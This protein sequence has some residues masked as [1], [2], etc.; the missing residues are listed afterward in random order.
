MFLEANIWS[1]EPNGEY[2]NRRHRQLTLEISQTLLCS[3]CR[4]DLRALVHI[5]STTCSLFKV[6][7]LV[8]LQPLADESKPADEVGPPLA[9]GT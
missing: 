5:N 2:P 3:T 4:A 1:R 8:L 9:V 6:V 7:Q